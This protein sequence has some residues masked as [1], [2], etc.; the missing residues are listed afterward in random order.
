MRNKTT[1][2]QVEKNRRIQ[3]SNM[4]SGKNRKTKPLLYWKVVKCNQ[5]IL[6]NLRKYHNKN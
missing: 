2:L 4:S 6:L 5:L 3:K 1:Y